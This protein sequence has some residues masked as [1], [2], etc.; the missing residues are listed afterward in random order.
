MDSFLNNYKETEVKK[1]AVE[2]IN[3]LELVLESY[4]IFSLVWSLCCTVDYDGR[5]KFS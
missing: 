3:E 5:E 2:D 1:V 4:L